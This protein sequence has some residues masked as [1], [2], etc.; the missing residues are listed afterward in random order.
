MLDLVPPAQRAPGAHARLLNR[1]LGARITR[2]PAAVPEQHRAVPVD[3]LLECALIT[4]ARELNQARVGVGRD[5]CAPR[6]PRGARPRR[7]VAGAVAV[8]RQ[9]IAFCLQRWPDREAR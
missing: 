9:A 2:D 8:R 3:D 6:Y 7:A 1:V 4:G 5:E